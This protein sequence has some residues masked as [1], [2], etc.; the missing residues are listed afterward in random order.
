MSVCWHIVNGG[1]EE[2]C[3]GV[4][5]LDIFN[6]FQGTSVVQGGET[7][8]CEEVVRAGGFKRRYS[9]GEIC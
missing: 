2:G 1:L 8:D 7:L 9:E 6:K 4:I 3:C 5:V